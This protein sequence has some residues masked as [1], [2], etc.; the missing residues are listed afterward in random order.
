MLQ[1]LTCLALSFLAFW[2]FIPQAAPALSTPL[3]DKS[4]VLDMHCHVAGIGAGGSGAF[5]SERLRD[6]WKYRIYLKAFGVTEEEVKARGDGLIVE[7]ISAQ[8]AASNRV[9]AAVLLA[10]DGVIDA[11]GQLDLERTES[12]IPND[13]LARE[14]AKY[15][16]LYFGA[17]V[18]PYRQDALKRLEQAKSTGAVL[19]KWLPAIQHID[20]ADEKL[21]SFYLKLV[22]LD[23]PLLT[24]AGDE[25]AFTGAENSFGDPC[26]LRLP[27]E[28]GV[29][30]IV[31]H[32]ATSGSNAGEDNLQRLLPMFTEF[33]NLYTDI[34]SLTQANKLRFLP[35]LLAAGIDP[36]RLLYGTDFPLISTG[37]ASP[38]F[39]SLQVSPVKTLP[40]LKIRNPWDQDVQLKL[41]HGVTSALF[42][43]AKQLLIK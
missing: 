36:S 24:H 42:S 19:I 33:P 37:I 31:A 13:F 12:Y 39:S 9:G 26:R 29:T 8:L 34:S 28:L 16:N 43:N 6:S 40:L 3:P 7:K 11:K 4:R 38:L 15:P 17:S 18:N 2:L 14:V 23:L 1:T 5:I 25:H 35:R 21:R 20:P 41:A 27:L 10:L 32:A 22:E 30:V